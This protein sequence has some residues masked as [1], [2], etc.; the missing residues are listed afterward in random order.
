MGQK[1]SH[2]PSIVL[3]RLACERHR[4]FRMGTAGPVCGLQ[5]AHRPGPIGGRHTAASPERM[6]TRLCHSG[7]NNHAIG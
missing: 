1:T 4:P 5:S 3:R 2:H 6:R 7:D